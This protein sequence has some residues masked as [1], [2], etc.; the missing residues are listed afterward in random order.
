MDTVPEVG[1]N[2]EHI[3]GKYDVNALSVNPVLY[4]DHNN[5]ER[6]LGLTFKEIS[7]DL[8]NQHLARFPY[9]FWSDCGHKS[10]QAENKL[11]PRNRRQSRP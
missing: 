5:N 7:Y 1:A 4:Y 9:S 11:S 8:P 2:G 3:L 10:C 6:R